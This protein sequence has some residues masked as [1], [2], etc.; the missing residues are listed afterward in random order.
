MASSSK[1]PQVRGL[2]AT[3]AE[4][5]RILKKYAD[6][7]RMETWCQHCL[8]NPVQ[9]SKC[10]A[11]SSEPNCKAQHCS[12]TWM[13]CATNSQPVNPGSRRMFTEI[14]VHAL[15]CRNCHLNGLSVKAKSAVLQLMGQATN[16][17]GMPMPPVQRVGIDKVRYP[18]SRLRRVK[19]RMRMLFFC[20]TCPAPVPV[21][22]RK[23]GR[24]GVD[25]ATSLPM[26]EI[27]IDYVN[28]LCR[29]TGVR[30]VCMYIYIYICIKTCC[31]FYVYI[32]NIYI[33]IYHTHIHMHI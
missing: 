25:S 8:V 5:H 15:D 6:P 4:P 14:A 7:L 10:G 16:W 23:A 13:Y 20:S 32:N 18:A 27:V 31:V 21:T 11:H 2:I 28:L 26:L 30:T 9:I 24:H 3:N 19:F 12:W 33:Y 22:L 1:D 17:M 29:C